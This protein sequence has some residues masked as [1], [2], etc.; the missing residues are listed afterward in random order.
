MIS[1][2]NFSMVSRSPQASAAV[3]S[4]AKSYA[5]ILGSN[6]RLNFAVLGLNGRGYAHLDAPARPTK[7][8]AHLPHLRRRLQ[9]PRQIRSQSADDTRLRS[10]H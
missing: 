3:S 4:T 8:R 1:R 10:S 9:H 2:R 7:G 6:N 5:Q